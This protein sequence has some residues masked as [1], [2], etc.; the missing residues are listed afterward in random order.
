MP[1]K[2]SPGHFFHK[3]VEIHHGKSVVPQIVAQSAA[4]HPFLKNPLQDHP[5]QRPMPHMSFVAHQ[6]SLRLT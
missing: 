2:D 5:V 3:R 1:G 6:I 4:G